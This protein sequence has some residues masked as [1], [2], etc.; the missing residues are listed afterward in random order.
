MHTFCGKIDLATLKAFCS[1]DLLAGG[2]FIANLVGI[3]HWG[4]SAAAAAAVRLGGA[5]KLL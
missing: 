2:I 3:F 5:S 4:L 1:P